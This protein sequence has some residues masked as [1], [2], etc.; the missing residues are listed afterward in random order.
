MSKSL[1]LSI[2]GLLVIGFIGSTPVMAEFPDFVLPDDVASSDNT[3]N[4]SST[5]P[6]VTT[7]SAL[8]LVLAL[9]GVVVWVARKYGNAQQTAGT[10]PED[11]FR[12]LGNSTIESGTRVTYL[13]VGNK[14]VVMGQSQNGQP[15]TLAEIDDPNEVERIVGRCLGRPEIIGRRSQTRHAGDASRYDDRQASQSRPGAP[16]RRSNVAAG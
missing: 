5:G 6:L 9:F 4:A 7:V 11:V 14:V 2:C 15:T 3:V 1:L 8:T 16:I 13:H 10:L 12:V